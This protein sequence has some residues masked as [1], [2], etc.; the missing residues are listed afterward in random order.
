MAHLYFFA[1]SFF[2]KGCREDVHTTMPNGNMEYDQYTVMYFYRK[3]V[4]FRL[5]CNRQ[6]LP[7]PWEATSCLTCFLFVARGVYRRFWTDTFAARLI[8]NTFYH[9]LPAKVLSLLLGCR[10]KCARCDNSPA[11]EWRD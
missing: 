6:N 2:E 1:C 5:Y 11:R 8:F 4:S 3:C 10:P 7:F 9:H